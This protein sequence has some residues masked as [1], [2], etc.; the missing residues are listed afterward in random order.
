MVSASD[1]AGVPSGSRSCCR[2]HQNRH[3]AS[4][5]SRSTTG[6]RL[7]MIVSAKSTAKGSPATTNPAACALWSRDPVFI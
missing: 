7:V 1:G 5:A 2:P 4:S 6:S 3:A